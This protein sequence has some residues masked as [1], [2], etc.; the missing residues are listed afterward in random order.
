[1]TIFATSEHLW[2]T[3]GRKCIFFFFLCQDYANVCTQLYTKRCRITWQV[4]HVKFYVPGSRC[5]D[6]HTFPGVN[7]FT[8]IPSYSHNHDTKERKM[9]S[10]LLLC[11]QHIATF[12]SVI[13]KHFKKSEK[14]ECRACV[15]LR[16]YA[17]V[18]KVCQHMKAWKTPDATLVVSRINNIDQTVLMC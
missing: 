3:L 8:Q 10:G 4:F 11:N 5:A 12:P 13:N 14:A 18:F 7:S 2:N 17:C 6:C 16:V 9:M 15:W 1:M